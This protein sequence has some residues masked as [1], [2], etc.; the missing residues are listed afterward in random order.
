MAVCVR[1]CVQRAFDYN[2][3]S[4]FFV[5]ARYCWHFISFLFLCIRFSFYLSPFDVFFYTYMYIK[6]I[7]YGAHLTNA[8][9]ALNI[10]KWIHRIFHKILLHTALWIEWK[11]ENMFFLIKLND[12]A[13]CTNILETNELCETGDAPSISSSIWKNYNLNLNPSNE[14]GTTVNENS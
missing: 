2:E 3:W 9:T 11:K 5:L 4:Q 1:V 7:V 12:K 14:F 6:Y 13:F 10:P 8:T